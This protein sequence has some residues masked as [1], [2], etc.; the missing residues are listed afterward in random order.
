VGKDGLA[1]VA[2]GHAVAGWQVTSQ[3]AAFNDCVWPEPSIGSFLDDFTG[4]EIRKIRMSGA[5]AWH[6]GNAPV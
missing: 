1:R 2:V 5:R 6:D 4:V 3:A